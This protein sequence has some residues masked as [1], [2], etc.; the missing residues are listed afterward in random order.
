MQQLAQDVV[1]RAKQSPDQLAVVDGTGSHSVSRIVEHAN[2]GLAARV[3][4]ARFE[5]ADRTGAY[6]LKG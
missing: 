2:R 6:N 1:E 5:E 3:E 4:D